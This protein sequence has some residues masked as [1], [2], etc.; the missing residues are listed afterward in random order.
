MTKKKHYKLV[1]SKLNGVYL[2]WFLLLL[3]VMLFSHNKLVNGIILLFGSMSLTLL[4]AYLIDREA[5]RT[6]S[7]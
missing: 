4:C 3:L 2:F 5:E 7:V 6:K 1:P